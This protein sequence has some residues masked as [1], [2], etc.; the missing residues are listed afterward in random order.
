MA[1][2]LEIIYRIVT[3]RTP[4]GV[5][6]HSWSNYLTGLSFTQNKP[7]VGRYLAYRVDILEKHSY[8][9]IP[10]G[11]KVAVDVWAEKPYVEPNSGATIR[12]PSGH[13]SVWH[14]DHDYWWAWHQADMKNTFGDNPAKISSQLQDFFDLR[15]VEESTV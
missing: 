8:I 7:T 1:E 12:Y 6:L 4:R 15:D 11:G 3:T 10:D 13:V 14:K 5:S 2:N 9:V